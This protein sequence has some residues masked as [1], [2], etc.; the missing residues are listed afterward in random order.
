MLHVNFLLLSSAYPLGEFLIVGDGSW[1][2]DNTDCVRKFDDNFFPDVASVSIVDIVD[3]IEDN[4]LHILQVVWII[5]EHSLQDFSCHN[6][7]WSISVQSHISRQHT[8]V[9]EF[10]FEVAV[11]LVG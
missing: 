9:T 6:H 2:H 10:K 8:N 7:A 4:I 11:F 1:K 3:F 5:V